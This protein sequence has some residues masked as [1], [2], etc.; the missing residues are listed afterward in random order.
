MGL[1]IDFDPDDPHVV[2]GR[3][4]ALGRGTA[5]C[6]RRPHACC[7]KDPGPR[8]PAHVPKAVAGRV[9][10]EVPALSTER[11]RH[12]LHSRGRVRVTGHTEPDFVFLIR[13]GVE[14]LADFSS[15]WNAD[16]ADPMSVLPFATDVRNSAS[17]DS[18]AGDGRASG[19]KNHR[20]AGVRSILE[21]AVHKTFLGKAYRQ[22]EAQRCN[23][24]GTRAPDGTLHSCLLARR[25]GPRP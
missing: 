19:R 3:H 20:V 13:L 14:G 21:A 9:E 22:Q 25:D 15:T 10:R 18:P 1:H 2:H 16:A 8:V 17:D 24:H 23:Q 4:G 12:A 6:E 11:D 7:S 5:D